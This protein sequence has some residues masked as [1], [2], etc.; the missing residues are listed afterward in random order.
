MS[1]ELIITRDYP[2]SVQR[3]FA[4]WHQPAQL[5]RWFAPG[6]MTVPEAQVD[7]RVGGRYR[8]VMQGES[9]HIVIGEYTE[10]RP[11]ECI[12]CSWQ[13]EGSEMIS[14]LRVE[15]E[16]LDEGQC[17]LTLRHSEFPDKETRDSHAEGWQEC[18]VN[19]ESVVVHGRQH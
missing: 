8:V 11:D 4:A 6:E 14:A 19:F 2:I 17:R 1:N 3:A 13:W 12:A 15:F 9:E 10:I 18:L 16:A 7:F 5:T